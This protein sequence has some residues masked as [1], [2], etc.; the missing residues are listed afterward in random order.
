MIDKANLDPPTKL[1]ELIRQHLPTHVFLNFE[2]KN[3]L[4]WNAKEKRYDFSGIKGDI[5]KVMLNAEYLHEDDI[6]DKKNQ[7]NDNYL[8]L[9]LQNVYRPTEGIYLMTDMTVTEGEWF[10]KVETLVGNVIPSS[11]QCSGSHFKIL[12]ISGTHGDVEGKTKAVS[13]FSDKSMLQKKIYNADIER[14]KELKKKYPH[15]KIKV[16]DMEEVNKDWVKKNKPNSN[17]RKELINFFEKTKP[18]MVIFDFCYSTNGD[19]CMALRSNAVFSR[20]LL[21]A[22]MRSMGIQKAKLNEKQVQ[23]LKIAADN[24]NVKVIAL[25]G[26][27]GQRVLNRWRKN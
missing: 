25:A 1:L 19:I 15:L 16:K 17:H 7:K 24:D 4:T 11:A 18:D 12:I 8:F 27:P 13:G 9:E 20:M 2:H 10:E 5:T 6:L 26:G 14:K 22:D 21:E 3:V 23:I